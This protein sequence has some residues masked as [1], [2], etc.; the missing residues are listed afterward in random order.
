MSPSAPNSPC[1]SV[2]NIG[3]AGWC[4]GCYRTLPEIAGWMRLDAAAQ[5][6]VIRACEARRTASARGAATTV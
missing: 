2:C 3:P 5:W 4:V 1:I 6:A